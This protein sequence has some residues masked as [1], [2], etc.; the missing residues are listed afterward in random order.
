MNSPGVYIKEV[1]LFPP[2]V[3]EVETAIPAFIGYTEKNGV[4][5]G[6]VD[7]REVGFLHEFEEYFGGPPPISPTVSLD[8]HNN[9]TDVDLGEQ[10]FLLYDSLRL[11]FDNGGGKCFIVSVGT[12]NAKSFT[13]GDIIAGLNKLEKEDEPTLILA[14]D[15]VR[16]SADDFYGKFQ[17]QALIQCNRLQDRFLICDLL[18]TPEGFSK[19][20]DTFRQG[21]GINYLKYGAAYVPWLK[22]NFSKKVLFRNITLQRSRSNAPLELNNLTTDPDI[23]NF[24]D[25]GLKAAIKAVDDINESVIKSNITGKNTTLINQFNS[26]IDTYEANEPYAESADEQTLQQGLGN[27]YAFLIDVLHGMVTNVLTSVTPS[28]TNPLHEKFTLQIDL[29]TIIRNTNLAEEMRQLICHSNAFNAAYND[30]EIPIID[31]SSS[32]FTSTICAFNNLIEPDIEV[33]ATNTGIS[34]QYADA[35]ADLNDRGNL[36]KNA[37]IDAFVSIDSAVNALLAAALEY[38]SKFDNSLAEIFGTYANILARIN[39]SLSELPPSGAIAGVYAATDRLRGVWKSPANISLASV[40]GPTVKIDSAEQDDLNVEVNAGKSINAIRAFTG[41]GT[42][43]WGAR[44]LAGND[45]EWRYISVRRFFNMVEESVKKSTSW[46]VFEPNDAN[47][48]NKVKTMIENYLNQK[49]RDGALAGAKPDQA[50][51]VKVG[52]GT[53]MTAQDILEGRMNVEIGMAVV[54]PAEFIILK[55]SHKLQEA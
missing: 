35:D 7:V 17:Q 31:Q 52:L 1:S 9:V 20:V 44:T 16:F 37:A 13:I 5:E 10:R 41:R 48:W 28:A 47:T 18:S 53:T 39:E 40:V 49:W 55:F 27:I 50:F 11:F 23:R 34:N 51:Y 12:Y 15:A 3:A 4:Q 26:L 54:R 32:N 19:D 33:N 38:E 22:T 46:A 24:I 14:P 42:L 36:A 25:T 2:S 30:I 21:I 6:D 43:V 29:E 45:N 8:S